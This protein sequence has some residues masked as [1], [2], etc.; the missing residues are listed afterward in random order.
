MAKKG[1]KTKATPRT[2]NAYTKKLKLSA[3]V[4]SRL[5]EK[6]LQEKGRIE[7]ELKKTTVG[8]QTN[9]SV[10]FRLKEAKKIYNSDID[11]TD[12]PFP[13]A[14]NIPGVIIPSAVDSLRGL[15]ARALKVEPFCQALNEP[16]P[17]ISVKK[18]KYVDETLRTGINLGMETVK[19]AIHDAI[20]RGVGFN[21]RY[22][23]VSAT[24]SRR[25]K[26]YSGE[27]GLEEF[28]KDYNA[29]E[30]PDILARL[31]DGD[32]ITLREIEERENRE[33][34][35]EYIDPENML[36][37][38][39]ERDIN[40]ADFVGEITEYTVEQILEEDFDGVEDLFDGKPEE[41]CL[42]EEV[43]EVL[44]CEIMFD[45]KG[46]GVRRKMYCCLAVE[47]NSLLL[48][49]EHPN[50]NG[51]S[52][53]IPYFSS[54]YSGNF[55][56]DGVY[57]K[58]KAIHQSHKE[59]VDIV[60]NSSYITMIP[61]FIAKK[62]GGFDPTRN[63]W[64]P[65]SVWYLEEVDDVVPLTMPSPQL[66]FERWADKLQ[67]Y[68]YE[69]SG[70]SPYNQGAPVSAGES[71]EK[72][73]T[74]LAA[75]G[76]RIEEVIENINKGVNEL[77]FQILEDAAQGNK[78]LAEIGIS[79]E[80]FESGNQR[81]ISSLD[82]ASVNPDM[83]LQ[84]T[85]LV[86]DRVGQ[87][88]VLQQCIKPEAVAE[89]AREFFRSVGFGWENRV[90]EIVMSPEELHERELQMRIEALQR[91][92]EQAFA[93]QAEAIAEGLT[94]DDLADVQAMVQGGQG[95]GFGGV[96]GMEQ[97]FEGVGGQL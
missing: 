43:I 15:V 6:I 28:I 23:V 73:K 5:I 58:L 80:A 61:T 57:D 42:S 27:K 47:Q 17:D 13:D 52:L 83:I 50:D 11:F 41:A 78:L 94:A 12:W 86:L 90:D 1:K 8:L 10:A 26:K 65:G 81:Y 49:L 51:H 97:G 55:W 30:Y 69:R 53:Y 62:H 7:E 75:G 67:Q 88:P 56:R 9:N 87:D 44:N 63:A 38:P 37:S 35:L 64:F 66:Q 92:Q 96:G 22:S 16:D 74:L 68:G 40:R 46:D 59:V 70:V 31:I 77:I 24:E 21:K 84:R 4:E 18:V 60:L 39:T 72:I 25:N 93:Q 76:I 45:Y 34:I 32:T 29:E 85:L 89:I 20:L 48:A 14:S 71:G 82:I 91:Q 79:A 95:G 19:A 3:D 2:V 54:Q 33:Q 36:V